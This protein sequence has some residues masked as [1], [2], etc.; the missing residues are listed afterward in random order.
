MNGYLLYDSMRRATVRDAIKRAC[1]CAALVLAGVPL[2]AAA[3]A[4]PADELAAAVDTTAFR[5][6][7]DIVN[8]PAP[9]KDFLTRIA[10]R[11]HRTYEPQRAFAEAD[12]PSQLFQY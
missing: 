12:K 3:Q 4:V 10:A 5:T 8:L 6:R 11:P 9:L 2:T 1:G 7:S